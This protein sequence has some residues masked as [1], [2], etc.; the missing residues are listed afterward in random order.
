MLRLEP[1]MRVWLGGREILDEILSISNGSMDGVRSSHLIVVKT[2]GDQPG[3]EEL[4]G[5]VVVEFAQ[6]RI[7]SYD[8]P[9]MEFQT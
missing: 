2:L 6:K 9:T 1:H 4:H 8:W 5:T 7:K 3:L